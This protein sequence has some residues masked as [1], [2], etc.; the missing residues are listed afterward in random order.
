MATL[1]PDII[2]GAGNQGNSIVEVRDGL[3]GALITTFAAFTAAVTPS[4]QAPIH[5]ASLDS[6]GNGIADSIVVVQGSDGASRLIRFFN[7]LTGQLQRSIVESDPR[8]AGAYFVAALNNSSVPQVIPFVE[9]PSVGVTSVNVVNGN[10]VIEG[11]GGNDVVTITGTGVGGQYVV[12]T[13]QGS[14]TVSGVLGSMLINL[15][16][17]DDQLTINKAL[18]AGKISIAMEAGEDAVV[19][20][21]NTMVSSAGNLEIDLGAGSDSLTAQRTYIGAAQL[22]AGGD[23]DDQLVLAGS[24]TGGVFVLGISSAGATSISGGAGNDT[25][26]VRYSFIVGQW[27]FD[28]G[29]GNDAIGI[30][31]SA[32]TGNVVVAGGTDNDALAVDTN[33]FTSGVTINGNAGSDQ[34]KLANS[35][36]IQLA[37]LLGEDGADTANVQNLTAKNLQ[38]NLGTGADDAD[39]RS[40]SLDLLFAQLGDGDDELTVFGNLVNGAVDLDGGLGSL[41]RLFDLGNSFKS[42]VGKK[43]FEL[44][45]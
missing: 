45:A 4:F 5:V 16:G 11:D 23:G 41:D 20:G 6:D 36:G 29:Q 12:V 15:H 9:E 18:V 26:D 38:L 35:L 33:F 1:I 37:I 28:G 27:S 24:Y 43:A 2:V 44:F 17:G 39:V 34:M 3:T 31:T 40:N 7:P 22:F 13:A 14:Q 25:V 32:C 42:T 19:L 21:N 8:L 10:L 30:N